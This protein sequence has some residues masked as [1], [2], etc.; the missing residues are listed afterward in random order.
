MA[1]EGGSKGTLSRQALPAKFGE[2]PDAADATHRQDRLPAIKDEAFGN[3]DMAD[4]FSVYFGDADLLQSESAIFPDLVSET[5]SGSFPKRPTQHLPNRRQL[6]LGRVSDNHRH[7]LHL[8]WGCHPFQCVLIWHTNSG[9]KGRVGNMGMEKTQRQFWEN[10]WQRRQEWGEWDEVSQLQYDALKIL[11]PELA[12]FQVLEAGSGTGRVSLRLAKEGAKVT[13]LDFSE[14]AL[15]LSRQL[16]G[17]WG[18]SAATVV[19]S[20]SALP[21]RDD[22]FTLVWNGGVL[23]HYSEAEQRRMLSEMVRVSAQ[24]VVVMVPYR[25][26]LF[27]RWAKGYLELRGKWV[28]G[29]E[30]PLET[31]AP[32]VPADAVLVRE[33]DIGRETTLRWLRSFDFLPRPLRRPETVPSFYRW[34][35]QRVRGYLLVA[36][37][38]K[39]R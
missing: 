18:I 31:L 14:E 27:Y 25:K 8:L 4:D 19:G 10:F 35:L 3:P 11:F 2:R 24:W 20:L 34:L 6:F 1:T 33:F 15:R 5:L 30:C 37:L 32:L 13:L 9:R 17:A 29:E 26:A 16:M 22:Q 38:Q 28:F 7:H 12:S 36:L 21:F 39:R 23:E